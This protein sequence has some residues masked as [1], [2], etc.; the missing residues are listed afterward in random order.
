MKLLIIWILS[1]IVTMS[2]GIHLKTLYEWKYVNFTWDPSQKEQMENSSYYDPMECALYDVDK[3]PDGRYFVTAVRGKGVPASLM[4]VT[5]QTGEGGPLLRP[6]PD[7][8]WYQTTNCLENHIISVFRVYIKCNYIFVLDCGKSELDASGLT[9]VCPPQLLIFNLKSDSLVKKIEIPE[10]YV[11]K[12]DSLLTTPTVKVKNCYKISDAMVS[13]ADTGSFGL[14][15]IQLKSWEMSNICRVESEDMKPTE[16]EFTIDDESFYLNDG[17]LGMTYM[18][19]CHHNHN[20]DLYYSPLAGN[21][22]F[23]MD[24]YK[25]KSCSGFK[26]SNDQLV[27]TLSGQTGPM[28][29][30]GSIIFFSNI[31]KTAI[32]CMDTSEKRNANKTDVV[33]QDAV[34]LQFTSGMKINEELHNKTRKEEQHKCTK[35]CSG[36]LNVMTNRYQ[37]IANH[38]MNMNETNF[39]VM[40]M[41]VKEICENTNCF[42]SYNSWHN[43]HTKHH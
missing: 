7:W 33:V 22:I 34:N 21:A 27:T 42:E 43:H 11:S 39:R 35:I 30:K 32:M 3:A 31:P 15:T 10:E 6:Y 23:K 29:S 37:K 8:S 20:S 26:K 25:L 9:T 4:T 38:D 1:A 41:D 36:E 2:Y 18:S 24:G 17:I 14:L 28:A 16:P 19:E 13:L 40:R 12:N 5:D